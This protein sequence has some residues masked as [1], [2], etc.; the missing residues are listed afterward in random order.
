LTLNILGTG[1]SG[2][3]GGHLVENLVNDAH[4]V[5]NIDN[6]LTGAPQNLGRLRGGSNLTFIPQDMAQPRGATFIPI[7]GGSPRKKRDG[8]L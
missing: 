4:K 7:F 6:F 1:G 5:L 2:F 8:F 3:I